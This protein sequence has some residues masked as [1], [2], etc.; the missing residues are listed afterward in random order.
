MNFD[1]IWKW[2]LLLVFEPKR[3]RLL[4]FLV[5]IALNGYVRVE[6]EIE[7]GGVS[8]MFFEI[9]SL[10]VVHEAMFPEIFFLL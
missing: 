5:E 6:A 10:L 1:P 8:C 9:G 3:W 2:F 4:E 7:L